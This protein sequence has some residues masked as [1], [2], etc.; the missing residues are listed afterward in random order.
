MK[1]KRRMRKRKDEKEQE[2]EEEE[3]RRSR[4]RGG[5]EG[6]GAGGSAQ[7]PNKYFNQVEKILKPFFSSIMLYLLHY[8]TGSSHQH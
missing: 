2:E 3:E 8:C 6:G 4:R 7:R 5:A 1:M